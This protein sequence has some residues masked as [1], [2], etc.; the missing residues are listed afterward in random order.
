MRKYAIAYILGII[1]VGL[2]S[3]QAGVS[4]TTIK[5]M[6]PKSTV[7]VQSGDWQKY[8][9]QGY[10]IQNISVGPNSWTTVLLVKY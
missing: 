8:V 9:R 4:S 10:Q 1:T 5:P 3:F 7:I 6:K 2:L